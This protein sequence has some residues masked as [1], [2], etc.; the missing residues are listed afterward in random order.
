[1]IR[2][3]F[4]L[5][6]R[7]SARRGGGCF[8][9]Q[10]ASTS[11]NDAMPAPS[12]FVFTPRGWRIER[13]LPLIDNDL[14]TFI[15]IEPGHRSPS[16]ESLP[17]VHL[18]LPEFLMILVDRNLSIPRT[19]RR[20]KIAAQHPIGLVFL[21]RQAGHLVQPDPCVC[22]RV[23]VQP[24]QNAGHIVGPELPLH[25]QGGGAGNAAC[26]FRVVARAIGVVARGGNRRGGEEENEK[27]QGQSPVAQRRKARAQRPQQALGGAPDAGS[28]QNREE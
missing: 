18:L 25:P 5:I 22:R 20:L 21:K 24:G 19:R 17:D 28:S 13:S 7:S 12:Q 27:R 1:M 15:Q 26:D 3:E 10:A 6:L 9:G 16:A 8:S 14:W 2:T 4:P 23:L 11:I